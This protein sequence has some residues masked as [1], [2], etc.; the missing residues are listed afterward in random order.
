MGVINLTIDGL[1]LKT[2]H[3]E[4]SESKGIAIS[5]S[6]FLG[7]GTLNE[8]GKSALTCNNSR[9]TVINCHFEENTGFNGG[10]ISIE[11]TNL[12]LINC[13]FFRNIANIYGGAI[14]CNVKQYNSERLAGR[15][16]NRNSC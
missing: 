9:I 5:N 13:T 7:N 2:T 16:F 6:I 11:V 4:V 14:L 8:N 15:G 1:T 10:A 12:D 3:L